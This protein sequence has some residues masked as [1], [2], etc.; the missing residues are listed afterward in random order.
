MT[1]ATYKDIFE[2]ILAKLDAETLLRKNRT[3]DV[4]ILEERV[5]VQREV[6]R[7]RALRERTPVSLADVERAERLALGHSDYVRKYAHAAADLVF[8]ETPWA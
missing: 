7:L 6:N 1:G 3:L 2:T 4:W 5:C 8:A